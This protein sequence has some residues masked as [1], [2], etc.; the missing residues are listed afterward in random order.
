MELRTAPAPVAAACRSGVRLIKRPSWA[1]WRREISRALGAYPPVRNPP[2]LLPELSSRS[3]HGKILRLSLA[4]TKTE[5]GGKLFG[6]ADDP[7]QGS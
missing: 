2:P 7:T 3:K 4:K 5:M 6:A 1:L